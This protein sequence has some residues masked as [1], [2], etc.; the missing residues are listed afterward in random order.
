MTRRSFLMMGAALF[1]RLAAAKE[2]AS[3]EKQLRARGISAE[4]LRELEPE[5]RVLALKQAALLLGLEGL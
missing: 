1:Y 5:I 4:V 2:I 3:L